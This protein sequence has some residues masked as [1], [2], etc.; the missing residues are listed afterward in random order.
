[1]EEKVYELL[2]TNPKG[3]VVFYGQIAEY[4]GHTKLVMVV[5]NILHNNLDQAKYPGY[6]VV[7]SKGKL[8]KKFCAWRNRKTKRKIGE[9]WHNCYQL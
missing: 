7:H 4:L 1:M 8:S 5:G 6:K 2:R 9:R 3:K